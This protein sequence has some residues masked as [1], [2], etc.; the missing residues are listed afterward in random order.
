MTRLTEHDVR[1]LGERLGEFEEGL[2]RVTGCGLLAVAEQ[3]ADAGPGAAARL[4]GARLA[5]VPISAGQGFIPGFAEC[6]A[7]IL[8]R[9]GGDAF[10]TS[11]PDMRGWQAA[12]A[13]G[14]EAVFAADD[15]R[16]VALNIHSGVCVDDDPATAAGFVAALGAAAGGLAG[17]PVL[18]LG[19]G[20]VGRAAA[21]RLRHLGADV[22]VVERDQARVAAAAAA[23]LEF[24]RVALDEGLA[25]CRLVLDATP[26]ADLVDASWVTAESIAAVP[27]L[28]SAF[29]A[30]GQTALGDRHIHELLALGVAVMAVQVLA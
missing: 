13:G 11:E 21:A 17:R 15:Y 3:A 8:A 6:V 30:A 14:A 9:L 24:R 18:V 12:A 27:G 28:P 2:R 25:A 22:L 1:R 26:S 16:F 19:L 10:V 29:T 4:A 23:G 5:V 20:P 7:A